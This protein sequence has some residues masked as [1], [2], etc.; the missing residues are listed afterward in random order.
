[1]SAVLISAA[2][3]C[4]P[5]KIVSTISSASSGV[6]SGLPAI[7]KPVA[8]SLIDPIRISIRALSRPRRN[9]ST[10]RPLSLRPRPARRRRRRRTRVQL[11]VCGSAVPGGAQMTLWMK[12]QNSGLRARALEHRSRQHLHA[13]FERAGCVH[14]RVHDRAVLLESGVDQRLQHAVF[15][16]KEVI[17]RRL[18]DA[19]PPRRSPAPQ[20]RRSL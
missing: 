17:Q 16:S 13:V 20:W 19:R 12:R 1:M 10:A 7:T 6:S 3:H 18:G 5:L 15:A 8:A 11:S 14:R 2:S 4:H 9:L